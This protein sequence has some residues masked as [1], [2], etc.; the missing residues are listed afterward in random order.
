MQPRPDLDGRPKLVLGGLLRWTVLV[1][2]SGISC[3]PSFEMA[4]PLAE[5]GIAAF[6]R[7]FN[8]GQFAEIYSA[9]AP[10]LR[11]AVPE[12]TFVTTLR[13][14]RQELGRCASVHPKRWQGKRMLGSATVYMLETESEFERARVGEQFEFVVANGRAQLVRYT[15]LPSPRSAKAA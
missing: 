2:L 11:A 4:R 9:A 1:C 3:G 7:S 5:N 12:A 6:H 13:K 10:Q 15:L 8:L 14:A